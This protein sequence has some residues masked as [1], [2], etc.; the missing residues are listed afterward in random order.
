MQIMLDGDQKITFKCVV[1][2]AESKHLCKTLKL[3]DGCAA[4][5]NFM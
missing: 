5:L 2:F 3:L 1:K 4:N